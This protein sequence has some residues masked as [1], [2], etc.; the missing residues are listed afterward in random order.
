MNKYIQNMGKINLRL[1]EKIPAGKWKESIYHHRV[2]DEKKYNI[3]IPCGTVNNIFVLDID[4][5]DNG[6]EEFN[7][8]ISIHG[9][10]NT[11]TIKTPSGGRH[12]YFNLKS[13]EDSVIIL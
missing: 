7:K 11:F 9:E 2:I 5:K 8:Y 6:F 10:P 3:G 4:I 12:Y 13:N 1:N